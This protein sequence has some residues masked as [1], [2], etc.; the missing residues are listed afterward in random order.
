MAEHGE[1]SIDIGGRV[2]RVLNE[3]GC[4]SGCELT[5]ITANAGKILRRIELGEGYR[6]GCAGAESEAWSGACEQQLGLLNASHAAKLK[7]KARG[8]KGTL[9]RT[10]GAAFKAEAVVS[11][12]TAKSGPAPSSATGAMVAWLRPP[13]GLGSD[14]IQHEACTSTHA[15]HCKHNQ[16]DM[17]M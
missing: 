3:G 11:A 7:T 8:S 1:V 15:H 14:A 10:C 6:H 4:G 5:C 12:S 16:H 2:L 17:H 13:E 9:E